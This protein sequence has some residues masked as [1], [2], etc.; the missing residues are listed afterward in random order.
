MATLHVAH[1]PAIVRAAGP[2]ARVGV[3]F[4]V[5]RTVRPEEDSVMTQS[6]F[7]WL[8]RSSCAQAGEENSPLI[9]TPAVQR[10]AARGTAR[11]PA[12]A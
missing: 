12:I 5:S 10:A 4:L 7:P 6:W 11:G 9:Q 8:R 3:S 2:H 1:Q